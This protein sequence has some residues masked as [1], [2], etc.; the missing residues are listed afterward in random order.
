MP[1]ARSRRPGHGPGSVAGADLAGVLGEGHVAH[2][3]QR[4]D[5]PVPAQEIGEAGRAGLLEAEA[6]ET[7]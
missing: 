6:G 1:M 5:G 7:A 3:A 2:M 4:L